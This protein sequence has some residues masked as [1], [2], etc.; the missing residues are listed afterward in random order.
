MIEPFIKRLGA[1]APCLFL[2]AAPVSAHSWSTVTTP[3]GSVGVM[4]LL[5]DGN[6]LANGNN[7]SNGSST[8]YLLTPDSS[9]HYA[10]GKWSTVSSMNDTRLFFSS[11]VFPDGRVFVAGGEYGAG[12]ATSE[13][14][15]PRT[16]SHYPGHQAA[17]S[18]NPWTRINPPTS[19][20]NPAQPSPALASGNQAF[21]DSTS[22]LFGTGIVLITPVGPVSYGG[23]LIYNPS[24][25]WSAGPTLANGEP[26][27]DEASFVKLPD[28]SIITI[29]PNNQTTQRFIPTS[30]GLT[31]TWAPDASV[32][33]QMY[34]S[35]VGEIGAATLLPNGNAFFQGGPGHTVIYTPS[36]TTANG[37]W[38]QGPDI[39][40]SLAPDDAPMAMMPN[41]KA[42]MAESPKSTSNNKYPGPTSYF[43][44]DYSAGATGTF[45]EV[46]AAAGSGPTG[47]PNNLPRQN[48]PCYQKTMLDLP[49][50]TVICS[51]YST[52]LYIY[53][54]DA[55]S[56]STV[57]SLK[58]TISSVS[59][60]ADGTYHIVGTLLNGFSEGATY[61]DDAQMNTNFPIVS[62]QNGSRV[63]YART[64]GWSN[65]SVRQ[66][67][68]VETTDFDLPLGLPAGTYSLVVSASGL[69]SAPYTFSLSTAIV[70]VDFSAG[71]SGTGSYSNPYNTLNAGV[72]A[73]PSG[74]T[75]EIEGGGSSAETGVISKPL[76]IF[77]YVTAVIG[78]TAA[79]GASKAAMAV[80]A[81][82]AASS[83]GIP[84][85]GLPL[86]ARPA[87]H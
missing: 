85:S 49:D 42:L 82:A 62:L 18:S 61:G 36:G 73:A 66:A 57:T 83:P 33:V 35:V 4:L 72:N 78:S 48:G 10:D 19:L 43:E 64:H 16:D 50:G 6:V 69:T 40:Q 58:P 15:D 29:G 27:E 79:P 59:Q 22:E 71:G 13:I 56:N 44:Y 45:T 74:G 68:A 20:L 65:T 9:G 53:N 87:F 39:P 63:Y 30:S 8:W 52:N 37:T 46:G 2:L 75:I 84:G 81:P 5:P 25:G 70:W 86:H 76:S 31:G 21:L 34:D 55:N 23:T 60:N 47:G 1:V 12:A 41:G 80:A 77:S 3:P 67:G 32:P 54:P 24:T 17:T 28:N 7:D 11:Q 26:F 51:D 38:K 14:Y